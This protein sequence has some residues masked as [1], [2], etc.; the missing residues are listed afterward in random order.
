M[1]NK[2]AEFIQLTNKQYEELIKIQAE[3]YKQVLNICKENINNSEKLQ[4]I[5]TQISKI[6]EKILTEL[7]EMKVY[8]KIFIETTK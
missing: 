1:T 7:E 2:E 5:D 4:I 6:D 8:N 3:A